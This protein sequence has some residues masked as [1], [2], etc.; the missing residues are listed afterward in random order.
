LAKRGWWILAL[1]LLAGL[2]FW[3]RRPPKGPE[4]PTPPSPLPSSGSQPLPPP[5]P[6]VGAPPPPQTPSSVS[7]PQETRS[8]RLVAAIESPAGS[9]TGVLAVLSPTGQRLGQQNVSGDGAG[10][11]E[12]AALPP[13]P[14]R[15]LFVPT[16][17]GAPAVAE[18]TVPEQ[19]EASASLRLAAS[20][21]LQGK[22][23]DALQRPLP[24]VSVS[25]VLPGFVNRYPAAGDRSL[26]FGTWSQTLS[27]A[28][29]AGIARS[30]G[31]ALGSDGSLRLS[32]TSAKDGSFS[33]TGVPGVA[34]TV[35]VSYEK[36]RFPQACVPDVE[37]TILVPVQPAEP[38][39]D[40]S[41]EN[42]RKA[43]DVLLR[44]MVDHPE[45]GDAYWDQL[46]TLLRD[47][48]KRP[49]ASPADQKAVEDAIL[50]TDR[51]RATR[52]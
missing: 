16:R 40:P 34:L 27:S 10:S 42:F 48:M 49:G 9:F 39:P 25:V 46:K 26:L 8:G 32:A 6:P 30:G 35:D 20:T 23:L 2:A 4:T 15:V 52:K 43:V 38:T 14:C 1:V 13:G 12:F 3:L 47:W 31:Y 19:G 18:A 41:R 5:P 24:G 36:L 45:S 22:A 29:G 7:P 33:I 17:G 37:A 21:R 28:A 44:Q 51:Q 50:E 11:F